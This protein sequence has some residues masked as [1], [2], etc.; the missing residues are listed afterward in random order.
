MLAWAG[1]ARAFDLAQQPVRASLL[2]G[3]D[4]IAPGQF[5]TLAVRLTH[6][7]GWH[8]YWQVAGD[9]GLP[10]RIAWRLPPGFRAG[11]LQWPVPRRLA[12]GALV[13]YGYEGETLLL[14]R[15]ETPADLGPVAVEHLGAHVQWLMCRDVCIPAS[16]DL[17]LDL[18][19]VPAQTLRPSESAAAIDRAQR[20][21][22]QPISLNGASATRHGDRVRLA[23]TAPRPLRSLQFF[24]LDD[25]RF[26][27]SAA[28]V[29]SVDALSVRLDLT[30][31]AS[32]PP[33]APGPGTLRGVL[34]AD[35]GPD[36]DG[37][38]AG[39]VELPVGGD[40]A[41]H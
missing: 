16:A 19:V 10:T 13:D 26:E 35:G 7:P 14:A 22:P 12:I 23:F 17:V 18:P 34:V 37:G 38:W 3:S 30:L 40:P 25:G 24:P 27:A 8:S 33:E 11:E 2:A 36:A 1:G 29:L 4:G 9:S 5:L 28:P 41:R 31:S 21:V 6:A 39:V 20:L 32:A 15:V